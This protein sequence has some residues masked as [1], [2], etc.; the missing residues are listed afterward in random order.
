LDDLKAELMIKNNEYVELR[1]DYDDVVSKCQVFEQKINNYE[2]KHKQN[3]KNANNV[4]NNIFYTK[5]E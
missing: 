2:S 4:R 5:P 3:Q 1:M